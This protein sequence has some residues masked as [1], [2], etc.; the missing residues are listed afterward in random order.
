M[1]KQRISELRITP[2]IAL[3]SRCLIAALS[4][5][6]ATTCGTNDGRGTFV[7]KCSDLGTPAASGGMNSSW[8]SVRLSRCELYP[9]GAACN[10]NLGTWTGDDRDHPATFSRATDPDSITPAGAQL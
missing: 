6:D 9:D 2:A 1:L 8:G 10:I 5:A 3:A 7:V 4:P